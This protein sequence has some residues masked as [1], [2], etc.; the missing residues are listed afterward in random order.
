MMPTHGDDEQLYFAGL[1]PYYAGEL[2]YAVQVV[3]LT[4]HRSLTNTRVHEMLNGLWATGV[5]NYPIFGYTL[6][7]RI[8]DR[9]ATYRVYAQNNIS[10]EDLVGF[11]VEQFRRFQPQV[12]VGH[13]IKGE[14]G[15]APGKVSE[16]LQKLVLG[17]EK[18][19]TGRFADTLE[20]GFEAAK[21]EIGDLAHSEED[22]LSYI[23]FPQQAKAFF[24]E[25]AERE[26]R[27]FKYTIQEI[28]E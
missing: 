5:E 3:Y 13:D 17:D 9:D 16:D 11:V 7:F 23:A 2:D 20:P 21:E 6:D 24:E 10:K 19:F 12:V 8:D 18:P 4:N 15:Q 1:L 27:T 14:Y 28:K 25:R 26:K 22:V